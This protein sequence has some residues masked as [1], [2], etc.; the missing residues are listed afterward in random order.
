MALEGRTHEIGFGGL[1]KLQLSFSA[2]IVIYKLLVTRS[3]PALGSMLLNK[4]PESVPSSTALTFILS[5]GAYTNAK[6]GT[7]LM[8]SKAAPLI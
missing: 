2:D 1:V 4:P 6:E 8:K 7:F 5:E 3:N